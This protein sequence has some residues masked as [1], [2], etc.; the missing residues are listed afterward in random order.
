MQVSDFVKDLANMNPARINRKEVI[1][2]KKQAQKFTQ[3]VTLVQGVEFSVEEK[4]E[5]AELV[6]EAST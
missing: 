4:E 6:D 5:N 2:I 3:G 1:N